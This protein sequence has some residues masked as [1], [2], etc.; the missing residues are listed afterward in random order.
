MAKPSDNKIAAVIFL[1]LI[2]LMGIIMCSIFLHKK[3]QLTLPKIS[4]SIIIRSNISY[5]SSKMIYRDGLL[6]ADTN[7]IMTSVSFM[8]KNKISSVK[9]YCNVVGG[10][11]EYK[12]QSFDLEG[13]PNDTW[14][15]YISYRNS[16]E[17]S[18]NVMPYTTPIAIPISGK[19][20]HKN[21]SLNVHLKVC[22]PT[23]S[24][25]GFRD[26]VKTLDKIFSFY[27]ISPEEMISKKGY[28]EYMNRGPFITRSIIMIV[29]SSILF[30]IGILLL[31]NMLRNR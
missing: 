4:D 24:E 26:R 28:D 30:L 15:K 11:I 13:K 29:I 19:D 18:V 21:I 9:G 23:Y 1:L 6:D 31:I 3:K 8:F 25:N 10:N 14:E 17:L 22:Y 16:S 2:G 5:D 20:F 12:D 27:I 7:K